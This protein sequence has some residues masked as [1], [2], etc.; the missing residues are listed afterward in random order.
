[1]M[2]EC[3]NQIP[4]VAAAVLECFTS[5][6]LRSLGERL[7]TA[8]EKQGGAISDLF[9]IVNDLEEGP[10]KAKLLNLLMGENPYPAELIDRLMA[11]TIRK[12]RERSNKERDII[13]TRRI[14]E[15]ERAKDLELYNRLVGEKNRILLNEKGPA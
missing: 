13:L 3:P 6:E 4:A 8:A 1:M 15:A 5:E 9:S 14:R 10:V 2:M 11:D 7:L 12:I